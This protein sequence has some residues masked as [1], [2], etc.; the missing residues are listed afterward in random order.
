MVNRLFLCVVF[1]MLG[2]AK[3]NVET[4]KPLRLDINMRL[5][6]YQHVAKDIDSIEDQVYGD[7]EKKMNFLSLGQDVYAAD[8]A[9]QVAAAIERRKARLDEIEDILAKGYVGE[10]HNADLEIIDASLSGGSLTQVEALVRQ[11]NKD[12]AII[13]DA[14]AAKNGVAAEDVRRIVLN[15]HYQRAPK[16]YW[17]Q[18][19][20][21]GAWIQK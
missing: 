13:Y 20:A 7:N 2:C 11:E 10:N 8:A 5:D 4:A 6:V 15:D 16:G 21:E 9:P 12:R 1:I 14:T 17:F 19:G 3:V 18:M